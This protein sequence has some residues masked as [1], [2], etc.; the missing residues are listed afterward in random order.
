MTE[1]NQGGAPTASLVPRGVTVTGL[2][3]VHWR[4]GDGNPLGQIQ[5][6]HDDW[7]AN[8][9][10]LQVGV[11]LLRGK[12]N[13][14]PSW[15]GGGPVA[16]LTEYLDTA[17]N[18]MTAELNG[19]HY[20]ADFLGYLDQA[21]G[22]AQQLGLT[23]V[24]CASTRGWT[25]RPCRRATTSRSGSPA[26]P[27]RVRRHLRPVQ[28]A[29]AGR[30]LQ[31]RVARLA[32]LG[33]PVVVGKRT[34]WA[35]KNAECWPDAAS[36]VPAFLS[37]VSEL[38]GCGL[39]VWALLPRVLVVDQKEWAPTQILAS[40]KCDGS[41]AGR[42]PA[43]SSRP[44]SRPGPGSRSRALPCKG[45]KRRGDRCPGDGARVAGRAQPSAWPKPA[46]R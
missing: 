42:A 7:Y 38:G 19:C 26:R 33:I 45:D 3:S 35:T 13:A 6:A 39:I 10:R 8:T 29:G 18:G 36:T 27:L 41:V 16:A 2:A 14:T 30:G 17:G 32:G 25:T 4:T 23:V 46:C 22:L 11:P 34:N 15:H 31:R 24:L 43:S 37:Y 12:S 5:H 20:N 9:V 44:S 1:T 40:Y 21:V 28:R